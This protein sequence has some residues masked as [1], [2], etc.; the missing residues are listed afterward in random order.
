MSL[1]SIFIFLNIPEEVR[2]EKEMWDVAIAEIFFRIS[3][4]KLVCGQ[5]IPARRQAE[6]KIIHHL[7]IVNNR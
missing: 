2:S 3:K 1:E 4:T 6:L 5:P 7:E